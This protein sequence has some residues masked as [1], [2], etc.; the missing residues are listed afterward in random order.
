MDKYIKQI[1]DAITARVPG[2]PIVIVV[3]R[4]GGKRAVT[5]TPKKAPLSDEDLVKYV[6]TT[7]LPYCAK[8]ARHFDR[9]HTCMHSRLQKLVQCKILAVKTTDPGY[10][11]QPV[12]EYYLP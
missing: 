10:G 5:V 12:K 6:A 3:Q 2:T 11:R 4:G 9:S 1:T 8:M 7:R